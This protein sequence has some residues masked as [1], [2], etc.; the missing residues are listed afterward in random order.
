MRTPIDSLAGLE[1][2]ITFAQQHEVSWVR[3]P[4]TEP[5]GSWGVHQT[6]TPPYNRLFGPVHARG[7]VSGVILQNGALVR[8]FG[9]P[10]RADLTFSVAKA[11]LGLLA[12]VAHDQGLLPDVHQAIVN[13]LPGIGFDDGQNRQIT[14]A[15][16]LQQ[17]SEWSGTCFDIPDQVDHFRSLA[18]APAPAGR[19]GSQRE[20]QAPGSF[21]EY[22]DVRI[23]QL[24]L[25][26]LHLFKTPLPEVFAQTIA[27]P[28]GLSDSWRWVGYDHAW[29]TIDGQR[30]PSV[31]GG[32]HWGAGVSISA[33][34]QAKIG[35]M[36]LDQGMA[37][38]QRV[39]SV[40]WLM[41]MRT[42]CPLAPFYG[43]LVW[44]NHDKRIFPALP[45]DSYFGMGAGGHFT[46][47]EPSSG[48]VAVVRWLDT[49]KAS[50]F[51]SDVYEAL[52]TTG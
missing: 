50:A 48:L 45:E 2:A 46:L 13:E 6:D 29:V 10:E 8:A 51:L 31:P 34:D 16:L 43:Y 26:L 49:D 11:Y 44:L 32:S 36:M 21:W 17:T 5:N 41:R 1:H 42:P 40:D 3:D 23:N 35:Q 14:W 7:G 4:I 15:H 30:M 47:I 33:Y 28:C 37:N 38:G 39:V 22:N 27:K 20:L 52:K 12:G 9:E 24:S 18:F 19:K 25:A